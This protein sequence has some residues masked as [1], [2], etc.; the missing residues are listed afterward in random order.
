MAVL[1]ITHDW[2][3]L[4]DMCERAV[5]MYAGEVV[6]YAT[7]DELYA[8]PRHPY[9]TALLAANPHL[10]RPG[11]PLPSIA[12]TVPAPGQW[13][14]GCHFRARCPLAEPRCGADEIPLVRLADAH[15]SRCVR[16]E[17]RSGR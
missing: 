14:V 3:V 16:A 2:G 12:G 15:L 6:E 8:H 11:E 10:A 4:A 1:L 9:T 7:V 13:P 17:E 5:V